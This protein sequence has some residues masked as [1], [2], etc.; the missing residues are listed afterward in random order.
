MGLLQVEVALRQVAPTRVDSRDEEAYGLSVSAIGD[1]SSLA[2]SL[3]LKGEEG[4]AAM[5]KYLAAATVGLAVTAAVALFVPS[6]L[7]GT[8]TVC[9][10]AGLS[11][12]TVN[13]GLLVTNDNYCLLQNDTIS[14]GITILAGSDIELDASTVSGGINVTP[15]GEIEANPGSVFFGTPTT[16]TVYGGI[17]LNH[18]TDWDIETTKIVGNFT[19]NGGSSP[20]AS[21][22]FCGDS[23]I[24]NAQIANVSTGVSFFGDP[25]DE[26]FDCGGNTISGSLSVSNSSFFEMEAN[27]VGGS[28]FLNASD[29]EFNGNMIGG[30]LIC[31]NGTTIESGSFQGDPSGNTVRGANR[32]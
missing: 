5:R 29:L 15:G 21:P 20:E 1:S 24:G 10:P 2:Q 28:A 11:N 13:G 23:I 8:Q 6:A 12:T 32:C 22:T 18:P 4:R 19:V 9:P 30:S 16:S 27:T 25:I 17:T 3:R 26:F 31:S 14:G 7:A